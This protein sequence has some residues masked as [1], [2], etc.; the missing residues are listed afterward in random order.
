MRRPSLKWIPALLGGALA[1]LTLTP[2][3]GAPGQSALGTPTGIA[4][5]ELWSLWSMMNPMGTN[6]IRL[7]FP[8]APGISP[9]SAP[10]GALLYGV[11][12]TVF[13]HGVLAWNMAMAL[14]FAALAWGTLAVGKRISPNA[15][16]LAQVTLIFSVVGCASWAPMSRYLGVGAV[17]MMTVPLALALTDRWIQPGARRSVGL[18]AGVMT[19]FACLGHWSTTV[20][21][22]A[23]LVPMVSIQCRGLEGAD[24]WRRAAIALTPGVVFGCLHIALSHQSAAALN[25]EASTL[26]AAWVH[27]LEGALRLPATAATSLPAIG[28]LMLALAGVAS[29]PSRTSGWLVVG[30]WGVLL[31][32]G[33][34]PSGF[35]AYAPASQLSLRVPPLADLNSWWGIAPLV[36]LPFGLAA[37]V[38]VE[39]LHK[40]RKQR[41]AI[42]A[43]VLALIDQGLPGLNQQGDQ[44]FY[45][46]P[47][48]GTITA[49]SNMAPGGVLQLP[50]NAPAKH[51]LWQR[52]LNRP[53]STAPIGGRDGGLRISFLARMVTNQ[54]RDPQPRASTDSPMD[55]ATFLCA[56]ADI[57]TL[58]DLGFVAV[59]L[60]HTLAPT[61]WNT[62]ALTAVLGEPAFTDATATIWGLRNAVQTEELSPCALPPLVRS[63]EASK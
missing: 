2:V 53:L 34:G 58:S 11:L 40:V 1:I 5:G 24:I 50:A 26:G 10:A 29:R 57:A 41:L 45:S 47:S 9:F 48:A 17:P 15:P 20:F 32:A 8:G 28:I 18:A 51:R 21:T 22:I 55:P 7:G 54:S 13:G 38:G 27:R 6:A 63:A 25:I 35:E 49:L 61:T 37:M 42:A 4:P 14:G 56:K 12:A 31:A 43:L 19:A 30:A 39:V 62:D 23:I 46:A 3:L 60:D 59:V 44:V 16:L 33:M 52:S 36:A